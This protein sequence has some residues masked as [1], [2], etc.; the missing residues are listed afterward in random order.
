MN[1]EGVPTWCEEVHFEHGHRM[2]TD[3]NVPDLVDAEFGD[4]FRE[5]DGGQWLRIWT[6]KQQRWTYILDEF[7]PTTPVRICVL[8]PR[9][10]GS[11]CAHYMHQPISLLFP[12]DR[13]MLALELTYS[14]PPR[15]P[16]SIGATNF[17]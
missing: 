4:C 8:P 5:S 2:R 13:T 3:R 15:L 17:S 10:G 1:G 12:I 7:A 9:W 6:C 16:L 14:N 11:I